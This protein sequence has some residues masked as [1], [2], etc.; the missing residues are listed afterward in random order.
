[1][2]KCAS[3]T[4]VHTNWKKN[5]SWNCFFFNFCAQAWANLQKHG[6]RE[7]PKKCPGGAREMLFAC[8]SV[9]RRPAARE[10]KKSGQSAR[11][12]PTFSVRMVKLPPVFKGFD[13]QRLFCTGAVVFNGFLRLLKNT[14]PVQKVRFSCACAVK[15]SVRLPKTALRAEFWVWIVRFSRACAQK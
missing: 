9:V 3:T 5:G 6:A 2:E 11:G 15:M 14:A 4:P 1:M 10:F 12:C 7:V 13:D 8:F